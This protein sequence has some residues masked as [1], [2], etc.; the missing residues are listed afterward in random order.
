MCGA[1]RTQLVLDRPGRSPPLL[2]LGLPWPSALNLSSVS[3]GTGAG[4]RL[5]VKW[6]V[7]PVVGTEVA[8]R[9]TLRQLE[10]FLEMHDGAFVR[11]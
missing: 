6:D 8:E 11:P 5:G 1:A 4:S 2:G 10:T 7:L 3:R 9:G